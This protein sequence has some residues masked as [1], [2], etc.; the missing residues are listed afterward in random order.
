MSQQA[1]FAGRDL[2]VER[3]HDRIAGAFN[4]DFDD[5]RF[6]PEFVFMSDYVD[7]PS[8]PSSDARVR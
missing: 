7:T 4:L 3:G 5:R 1:V 2:A 6:K 8:G